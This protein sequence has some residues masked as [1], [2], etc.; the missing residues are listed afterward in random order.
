MFGEAI[1]ES[2][3]KVTV[4]D[5]P[6]VVGDRR[7]LA[8]VVPE[9][10]RQ[11]AQ[12]PGRGA[13]RGH[14]QRPSTDGDEHREPVADNGIGIPPEYADQIFTIFKRLHNKTE[15][16]GTGIGLALSKKIVEYHGGHIWL[17]TSETPGTT[18]CISL[19]L[20]QVA[21]RGPHGS[22]RPCR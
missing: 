9:P 21:R 15:Y 19:P 20:L 11:C 3:A 13:A 5:L 17:D 6:T 14:D 1:E 18:F 7:L 4:G 12:V 8:Q 2:G 22:E 10:G 16:D